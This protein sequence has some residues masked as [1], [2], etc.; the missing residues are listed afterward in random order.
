MERPST[1]PVPV[2]VPVPGLSASNICHSHCCACAD[3]LTGV[4]RGGTAPTDE[5]GNADEDADADEV[6]DERGTDEAG[7][8][9]DNGSRGGGGGADRDTG[10][11]A[12]RK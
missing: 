10:V 11:E 9:G 12:S 4:T 5:I 6:E 3:G 1:A 7:T 8:G 2:F